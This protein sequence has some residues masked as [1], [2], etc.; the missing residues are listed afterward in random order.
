MSEIVEKACGDAIRVEKSAPDQTKIEMKSY[1]LDD[2]G[3]L[4]KKWNM[5]NHK[6]KIYAN[7]EASNGSSINADLKTSLFEVMKMK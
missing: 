7:G 4:K 1:I 2:L 3:A 6:P 5:I